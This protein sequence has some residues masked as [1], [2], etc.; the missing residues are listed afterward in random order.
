MIFNIGQ[1]FICVFCG[2]KKYY[3]KRFPHNCGICNECKETLPLT[4]RNGCFE[5]GKYIKYVISAMFY[6]HYARDA[7]MRYKFEGWKCCDNVF[8]HIMS[9][10]IKDFEHLGEFDMVI[11]VP[12]S[13]ERINERGFNQSVPLALAVSQTANVSCFEN[14]LI[15]TRNTKRQSRLS[16]R[17]RYE[18]VKDAYKADLSVRGKRIILVDDIYTTGITMD[19]CAKT[20]LCAGAEDVIAVVLS[21]KRRKEKNPFIRY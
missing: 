14:S 11:P 3:G 15:K 16:Q 18:N 8:M 20:L 4:A 21:I 7:I 1:K 2:Q 9:K 10:H 5:G 19:E 12:L 17:E 13:Q 6:E